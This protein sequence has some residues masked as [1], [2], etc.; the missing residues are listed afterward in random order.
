MVGQFGLIAVGGIILG[1]A[2]GWITTQ[3]QERL[4]DPMLEL[5]M[6]LTTPF[7]TYLLCEWLQVSGVLGIVVVGLYRSRWGHADLDPA[8]AELEARFDP[9]PK[10]SVPTLTLHGALDPVNLPVMSAGKE[11]YFTGPYVR[12]LIDGAG[13]FPQRERVADTTSAIVDWL[14]RHC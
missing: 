4:D 5:A 12:R 2:M 1:V 14:R 7:A 10:Q 11:A 6:S 9:V 13:H 3:I 8:Y